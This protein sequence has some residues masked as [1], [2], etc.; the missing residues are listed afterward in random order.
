MLYQQPR[1]PLFPLLTPC[2]KLTPVH[3]VVSTTSLSCIPTSDTMSQTYSIPD[4]AP[5]IY[6]VLPSSSEECKLSWNP[7]PAEHHRGV[8][9]G[10]RVV[11]TAVND[12]KDSS[13]ITVDKSIYENVTV[14]G[15]KPY[16]DY[17]LK[18]AGFTSKG[19]GNY[20]IP[21]TCQTL[22]SVPSRR[23]GD[24]RVYNITSTSCEIR[25]GPV[26]VKRRNGIITGYQVK[27]ST[28]SSQSPTYIDIEA[29]T[30]SYRLTGLDIYTK[31]WISVVGKTSVGAGE[32]KWRSRTHFTT[33]ADYPSASPTGL[34]VVAST[35]QTCEI[36][37]SPIPDEDIN[38]ELVS[39][40]V[41]AVKNDS[42]D[43]GLDAGITVLVCNY[44]TKI[45]VS[46]LEVFTVYNIKVAVN[47]H[48]LSGNYSEAVEC[49]TGEAAPSLP[50]RNIRGYNTSGTSI[51]I[52]W[53]PVPE[54]YRNG[55]IREYHF[56]IWPLELPD[57]NF[58]DVNTTGDLYKEF[59]GLHPF[60]N[61]SIEMAAKLSPE[62][63]S[64]NLLLLQRARQLLKTAPQIV[65]VYNTSG[66]SIFVQWTPPP[67]PI[68]GILRGYKIRY[69]NMNIS[70]PIQEYSV[71]VST[72]SYEI[73]WLEAYTKYNITVLA[74]T[75]ADGLE[76]IPEMVYT[77]RKTLPP[78]DGIPENLELG[79]KT[80]TSCELRWK[81]AGNSIADPMEP[82]LWDVQGTN[83][84]NST[85]QD[86]E[87]F[88]NYEFNIVA[89]NNYGE[90]NASDVFQCKTE[91]D[92]PSLPPFNVTSL[93]VTPRGIEFEWDFPPERDWN[94]IIRGFTI[95][96]Y[97]KDEGNSSAKFVDVPI[98]SL[99]VQLP[100]NTGNTGKA[101]NISNSRRKRATD[102][103]WSLTGLEEYKIYI[104][105]VLLYTVGNSEYS[106]PVEIQ[107]AE[108]APS[109]P[110]TGILA[111]NGSST[112]IWVTWSEVPDI[113]QNGVIRGF[114]IGYWEKRDP[115]G[116]VTYANVSE[117]SAVQLQV[118]QQ[119]DRRRKELRVVL[120]I[121]MF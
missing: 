15:L 42:A 62:E 85:V 23:P 57:S 43:Q 12:T 89:Y 90:G 106:P 5:V 87:E 72:L 50:P 64:A 113:D 104:I 115:A 101:G 86:L 14:N 61:Y 82:H 48:I 22:E 81:A 30:Y 109:S 59:T 45:N 99:N 19:D 52:L 9:L 10:F 33:E 11:Y 88:T 97:R 1:G 79:G 26:P 107:T 119:S 34:S 36:T 2:H 83:I 103:A 60:W 95:M 58:S 8:L 39:Y 74:F 116:T 55:I 114:L 51:M 102:L 47:N 96:Y 32:H 77:A 56:H 24:R 68:P 91:E 69:Q 28:R 49:T 6:S 41:H 94:G 21:V 31:Y 18:V 84:T 3:H 92:A 40:E 121:S 7:I 80:S 44:T 120:H 20:S 38:G 37:W 16:T 105:R 70:G 25:W 13:N 54:A 118:G 53:D 4:A 73:K 63:T 108:D 93:R 110:P 35:P 98:N 76:S 66:R 75:V 17:L 71:D 46:K 78:P 27:Y 117:S 67:G 100:V 29:D 111:N 112:S 65:Q